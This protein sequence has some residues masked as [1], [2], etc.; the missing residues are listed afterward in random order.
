MELL[1]LLDEL[2]ERIS[3]K[4]RLVHLPSL[5]LTCKRFGAMGLSD[6]G[7]WEKRARMMFGR[8]LPVFKPCFW[9]DSVSNRDRY[10][11]L[12]YEEQA[13]VVR[14][15]D[16]DVAPGAFRVLRMFR[17]LTYTGPEEKWVYDVGKGIMRTGIGAPPPKP[18]LTWQKHKNVP[19]A[20]KSYLH[21]CLFIQNRERIV[22]AVRAFPAA[23]LA[24]MIGILNVSFSL[25]NRLKKIVKK[26]I[27]GKRKLV[28]TITEEILAR[29]ISNMKAVLARFDANPPTEPVSMPL[30]PANGLFK[31]IP[32]DIFA[33]LSFIKQAN[34]LGWRIYVNMREVRPVVSMMYQTPGTRWG[35]GRVKARV[36]NNVTR[37]V[38]GNIIDFGDANYSTDGWIDGLYAAVD[39]GEDV[40]DDGEMPELE[41]EQ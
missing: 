21:A 31:P 30:W 18:N 24:K 35:T 2:L 5:F 9:Y 3:Y 6:S 28:Y 26:H 1:A 13:K 39:D 22:G 14:F 33:V 27:I 19:F 11:C 12:H 36:W 7:Y 20:Y 17:K 40:S 8:P 25:I 10:L 41:E 34:R 29:Y 32:D 15:I 16:R 23:S 4:L 38:L 37:K